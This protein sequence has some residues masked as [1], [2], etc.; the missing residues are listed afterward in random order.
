MAARPAAT[1]CLSAEPH[2]HNIKD[3]LLHYL[4]CIEIYERKD[5]LDTKIYIWED[6]LR[7]QQSLRTDTP[8]PQVQQAED[9]RKTDQK[10]KGIWRDN[11]VKELRRISVLRHT[12]SVSKDKN[13]N[14]LVQEVEKSRTEWRESVDRDQINNIKDWRKVLGKE[15]SVLG[16]DIA[17]YAGAY[18]LED[19]ISV[20]VIRFRSYK[21]STQTYKDDLRGRFPNQKTTINQ[22]LYSEEANMLRRTQGS[23]DYRIA[24]FH[25]PSNNMA[26]STQAILSDSPLPPKVGITD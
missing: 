20:P 21:E 6:E 19:D 25:I 12:L 24:Y 16:P 18:V 8:A 22:L 13:D 14:Q 4:G 7:N 9:A 23:E 2:D 17:D 5:F 3:P 1:N 26:V 15:S 10:A 11:I